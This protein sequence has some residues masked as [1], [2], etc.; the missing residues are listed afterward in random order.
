[1]PAFW[2][3]ELSGGSQIFVKFVAPLVSSISGNI[4]DPIRGHESPLGCDAVSLG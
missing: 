4:K 2:C 1:M 3:L